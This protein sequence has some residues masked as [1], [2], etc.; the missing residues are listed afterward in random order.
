MKKKSIISLVFAM[1]VTSVFSGCGAADTTG[2]EVYS[3]EAGS[4]SNAE[5]AEVDDGVVSLKFRC[6]EAELVVYE[7]IVNQFVTEHASEAEFEVVFEHMGVG[8]CKDILL[9]DVNNA[10][11]IFVFPDDQLLA[12]VT[13]GVLEPIENSEEIKDL[14]LEGA[15]EAGSVNGDMYAY[16]LTADNGYFLYY[17]KNYFTE[18]DVKSLDRILEI[19]AENEKK[20][21]MDWT[22]GWY[23]YSFFGSTGLEVGMNAD[24]LTNYCNWN[25][26]EGNI[27]GVDVANAMLAIATHPGF[28]ARTDFGNAAQ[29]GVAIAGVSGVWDISGVTAAFGKNY[30]ACKLP[31]YTCAGQQVQMS[32]FKGYHL[33]GVNSYSQDSQWAAKLAEYITNEENQLLRFELKQRGPANKNAAASEAINQVPAIAAVIEQSEY[34]QL[35]KIGAAYWNPM[36]DFG[37]VLSQ[38]NLHGR[39]MQELLD[40]L[41]EGITEQ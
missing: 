8:D 36:T 22:S 16:P 37:T 14:Y 1:L 13:S 18:E 27:K 39:P 15:I 38:G 24:G 10:A 5:D 31:T 17:D 9:G 3:T 33:I 30:G 32:S 28:L 41:V 35:Q 11:D 40:T 2:E 12:L 26:T 19:C 20:F 23:L 34:G 25:T 6:D 21:V 29:E 4:V 7:E